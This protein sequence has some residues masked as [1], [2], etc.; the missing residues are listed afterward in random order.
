M[1]LLKKNFSK[2]I[3]FSLLFSFSAYSQSAISTEIL[4]KHLAIIA[5]DEFEG[6]E[7]G[8][9]GQLK[10][11]RYISG[12][13]EEAGLQKPVINAFGKSFFQDI[14]MHIGKLEEVRLDHE[15]NSL[16]WG[17]DFF[18]FNVYYP[19]ETTLNAVF[20]GY[21][22][23]TKEYSDYEG[24]DVK[25]KL[26][27]L[28][29]GEPKDKNGIYLL[30]GEEKNSI[31]GTRLGNYK[32]IKAARARGAED[33]LVIMPDQEKY[34]T[35]KSRLI[36]YSSKGSYL[37]PGEENLE[38]KKSK[39][40]G[41]YTYPEAFAAWAGLNPKALEKS[42]SNY[43]K[44]G[45]KPEIASLSIKI[46]TDYSLKEVITSNILG[47]LEGVELKDEYLIITAHYDHLGKS[48]EEI[49]NGADDD[50]SGTTALLAIAQEFGKRYANGEKTKRSI[51]FMAF[52]GEEK[53]LLGSKYYC[54]QAPVIPLEKT[55]CDL[56]IDMIG[57]IEDDHEGDSNYVYLIGSDMLSSKVHEISERTN[58]DCCQMNF[59]YKF[60]DFQDPNNF[61]KRSDHYNFAKNNIPVIFY[62]N[63]SH[64]DYHRPTDT[65]EKIDFEIFRNRTELIFQT[66]LSLANYEGK[67]EVDKSFEEPSE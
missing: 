23:D 67:I 11:A 54:N 41:L 45:K 65:I 32:K 2:A 3:Y 60:N 38:G 57:R 12:I 51:L 27:L 29:W 22:I 52:T 24:L 44:G 48:G 16:V 43:N 55:V 14:P 40:G 26:V 7:T 61:Y 15:G 47:K 19:E 6:R 56:N 58:E 66:A 30:S 53:G 33:I 31:W 25:G 21:G 20:V 62:F 59:D 36:K 50:G 13:F 4:R 18:G 9:L 46:K 35:R 28:I 8:S 34:E 63:G 10:A 64:E 49:Y 42:I 1:D 39:Y 17:S 5:S 37:L